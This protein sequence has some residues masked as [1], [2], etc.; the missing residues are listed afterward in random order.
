MQ[1]RKMQNLQLAVG[2]VN[3]TKIQYSFIKFYFIVF[4]F[5]STFK[6]NY[7]TAIIH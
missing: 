7:V 1:E 2:Y 6:Q 4:R 3:L 5:F